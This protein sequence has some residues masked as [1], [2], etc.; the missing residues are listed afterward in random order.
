MALNSFSHDGKSPKKVQL[1][2]DSNH[3]IAM[4]GYET[5]LEQKCKAWDC[6]Q[7]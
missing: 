4:Q 5:D 6:P 7:S 2:E 3:M 1:V